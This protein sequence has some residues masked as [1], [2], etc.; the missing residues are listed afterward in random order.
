MFF[1]LLQHHGGSCPGHVV[2]GRDGILWDFVCLVMR[3]S[4]PFGMC[5][6]PDAQQQ[7]DSSKL[8]LSLLKCLWTLLWRRPTSPRARPRCRRLSRPEHRRGLQGLRLKA[9][10]LLC[11]QGLVEVTRQDV[12][13]SMFIDST[14]L[15]SKPSS[16]E[17]QAKLPR[18]SCQDLIAELGTLQTKLLEAAL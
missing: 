8:G 15:K 18:W 7:S 11:R 6:V 4:P 17:R 1:K 10:A 3:G 9:T 14:L 2:V 5:M 13:W 16:G 12:P